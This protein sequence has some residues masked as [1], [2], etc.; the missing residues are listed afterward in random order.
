M[1]LF[2]SLP[3]TAS[4]TTVDQIAAVLEDEVITLTDLN[5]FIQDR[6][7]PVPAEDDLQQSFLLEILNQIIDQRLISREAEQTPFIQVT[8]Q[9][10]DAFIESRRRFES[11]QEFQQQLDRMGMSVHEFRET[12]YRRIAVNKFIQLRFEPFIIVLPDEIEEYYQEQYVPE[13]EANQEPVPP[14]SLVEESL[15]QLLSMEKTD[16]ELDRWLGNARRKHRV[17]ILLFRE[18]NQTPNL[19][20][21]LLGETFLKPIPL[22]K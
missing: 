16:R 2:G 15:R 10:I 11:E 9:E 1:I 4:G 5:W 21:E 8:P 14:L 7:L 20:P 18:P 3:A 6:N 13:R 22:P 17:E 19:P 12:V